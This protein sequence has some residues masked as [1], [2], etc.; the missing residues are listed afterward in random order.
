MA[1]AMSKTA[2]KSE[3]TC[4][5]VTGGAGYIGSHAVLALK[6]AG[7]RPVVIDN[8]STGFR[9]AVPD[10]VPLYEG[11][12]EDDALLARIFSEQG[13]GAVMHFAG[14]IVVP[15]SVADPLG[16]YLNNTV[17]SRALIGKVDCAPRSTAGP[18][19]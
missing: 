13:V 17:K 1:Q 15:D 8:L 3:K 10:D 14:S 16:Y 7:W 2:H 5:L 6:D 19:T 4:V 12:I 11:D 9:F 18:P